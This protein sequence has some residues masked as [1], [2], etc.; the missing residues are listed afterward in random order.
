MHYD[1]DKLYV[2]K[3]KNAGYPFS[4]EDESKEYVIS[5]E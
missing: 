1:V 3:I 5:T 4:S 2:F